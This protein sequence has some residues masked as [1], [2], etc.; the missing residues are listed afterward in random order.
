MI[1]GYLR[2]VWVVVCFGF[3]CDPAGSFGFGYVYDCGFVWF[4]LYLIM[5]TFWVGAGRWFLVGCL[6]VL[7]LGDCCLLCL[8]YCE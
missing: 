5:V 4:W 8:L 3:V 2:C 6:R 1:W 7:G